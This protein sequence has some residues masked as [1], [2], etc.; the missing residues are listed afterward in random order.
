MTTESGYFFKGHGPRW[1]IDVQRERQ[2]GPQA[3][4]GWGTAVSRSDEGGARDTVHLE[5][6]GAL[7]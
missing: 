5:V 4:H 2:H 3:T 1:W 7:T 6:E